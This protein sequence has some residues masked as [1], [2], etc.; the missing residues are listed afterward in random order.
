M[1]AAIEVATGLIA[2]YGPVVLPFAFALEG[3]LVGKV[4]PTRL[5]FVATAL[6]V[7]PSL[8]GL[9]TVFA[10]AVVGAT[11]GQAALFVLVRRTDRTIDLGPDTRTDEW[12]DEWGPS[13]V[14][15]SNALPVLRGSLTVPVAMTDETIVRF[16]ASSVAGT[17]V[18]TG[19]LLALAALVDVAFVVL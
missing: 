18:Y 8:V 12:L 19:G 9:A 15:L 2:Q 13:A 6:A 14:A 10:A 4:L 3:A 7:A 16:S 17:T 5:L 1:V 11:L